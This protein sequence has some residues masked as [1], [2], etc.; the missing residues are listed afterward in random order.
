MIWVSRPGSCCR[1]ASLMI[2]QWIVRSERS[3]YAD[4]WLEVRSADVELPDGRHLDHR[5]LRMPASAGAVA[6][7]DRGRALLIWRH[8]FITGLWGWEMPMGR[9]DPR[10]APAQAAAREVE[11]ETGWRPGP[12]RQLARVQPS[13]GIMDAAHYL[14]IADGATRTGAAADG[15]E[16]RRIAWVPLT[17]APKLIAKQEIVS[18]STITAL[19]LCLQAADRRNGPAGPGDAQD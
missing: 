9:I 11:E 14:F 18:S 13:S 7:D 8:R 16:S 12:L 17:D 2:M 3:L 1:R 5:L 10:E 15:F 19:L 4:Q 6:V